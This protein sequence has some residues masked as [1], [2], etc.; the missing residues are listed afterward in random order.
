MTYVWTLQGGLSL[1]VVMDL[2][3]RQA[4]GGA[5]DVHM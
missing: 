4:V 1:A 5:M 2:P 3:S